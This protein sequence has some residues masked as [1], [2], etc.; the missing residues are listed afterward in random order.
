V[1]NPIVIVIVGDAEGSVPHDYPR[2][3]PP[4]KRSVDLS[5]RRSCSGVA[6]LALPVA[7]AIASAPAAQ[8]YPCYYD[9]TSEDAQYVAVLA[10]K[11]ISN[12]NGP[13]GLATSGHEISNDLCG[14]ASPLAERDVL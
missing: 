9:T 2:F 10:H 5:A 11:G 14:R 1:D 4:Q 13:R 3:V 7:A 8:A 6:A 12:A